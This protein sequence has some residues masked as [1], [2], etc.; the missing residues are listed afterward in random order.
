[1]SIQVKC[2]NC[3]KGFKVKDMYAGL[4]G[5][6][7]YCSAQVVVPD[8]APV[9]T[10]VTDD[11]MLSVEYEQKSSTGS[12]SRSS[13]SLVTRVPKAPCPKCGKLNLVGNPACFYCSASL[14]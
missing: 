2:A 4:V 10:N 13:L 9:S 1:M 3:A 12:S 11:E 5:L 7:P 8:L 6:C 14:I